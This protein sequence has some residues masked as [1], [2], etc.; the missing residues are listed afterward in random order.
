MSNH[1]FDQ[2]VQLTETV[3][4]IPPERFSI[5]DALTQSA[6][7]LGM[8]FYIFAYSEMSQLNRPKH[9]A[10]TNASDWLKCYDEEKFSADDPVVQYVASGNTRPVFWSDLVDDKQRTTKAGRYLFM[11]ASSFGLNDGVS[12]PVQTSGVLGVLTFACSNKVEPEKKRLIAS[13]IVILSNAILKR[14][15]SSVEYSQSEGSEELS[16]REI[17]CLRWAADGKTAWEISAILGISERTVVFH[18]TNAGKKLNASSRQHAISKAI[19]RGLL[20]PKF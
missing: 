6:K 17:E 5:K 7:V 15:V 10:V 14:F 3:E 12:T 4:C 2:L 18:L 11:R 20:P 1:I 13:P 19:L 8:E 16:S 9:K